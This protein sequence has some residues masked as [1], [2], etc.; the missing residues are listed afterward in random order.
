MRTDSLISFSVRRNSFEGIWFPTAV[1]AAPVRWGG[2][3]PAVLVPGQVAQT[4]CFP[5]FNTCPPARF[6][7]KAFLVQNRALEAVWRTRALQ[8]TGFVDSI[9]PWAPSTPPVYLD[10]RISVIFLGSLRFCC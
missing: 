7:F 5:V 1:I 6:A 9:G 4:L 3:L 8:S 10:E 2:V